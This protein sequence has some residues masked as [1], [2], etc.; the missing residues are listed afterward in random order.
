[1]ERKIKLPIGIENFE[2]IRRE[3]FYYIDKSGL[4]RELLDN[5]GEVNLFTRPRRFGKSLNMSMLKCFFE[6]GTDPALFDGL[7]ISHDDVL[8]STYMGQFP[9]VSISLKG[10]TG[11]SYDM[12]R[13]MLCA[14]IG[15]EAMRFQMLTESD[16][17]TDLEKRQYR[18]LVNMDDQGQFFFSD[19]VLMNSLLVLCK[20]LQKHYERKVIILIDEYDV[21]LDKAQQCGYYDVMISL[22]RNLFNQALK[23]NE[24]LYFSVLTGCL[25]ISKESIFTGLNNPK[26]LSITDVRFDEHFGF[27]DDEVKALLD[28]Y[29]LNEKYEVIREWYD[30][31]RFG[32]VDV[33]CPWDV[34]C[35][36]DEL[37]AQPN[38]QPG[39]YWTNTSDNAIVRRFLQ[40]AQKGTTRR[41]IEK[42]MAG[43]SIQ[44]EIHQELTYKD[45]DK[46]IDN[47]WSVL[48]TTGYLT[49]QGEPVG[50]VFWLKI[51]NQEIRNIFTKQIYS[52]FQ[53]TAEEDGV[54]LSAFCDA[55]KNGDAEKIER[56]FDAYLAKTISIRDTFVRRK[57]NF[58]HGILLGLLAYKENWS[59]S[60][61]NESGD[62][63]SDI[64]IEIDDDETGIIIEVKYSD[65]DNMLKCCEAAL[66]Q[67][68]RMNYEASLINNGM[69][70]VLKYGIACNKKHC[71]VLLSPRPCDTLPVSSPPSF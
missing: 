39:N 50:D 49:Q 11:T 68:D 36:C 10:V 56:Q 40:K 37:R 61:N 17:L 63:Y 33:Y 13:A 57:E 30:G 2:K 45:L 23:G 38:A 32:S 54:T 62:G 41:E 64:L 58:Y 20:L 8:C 60:S 59:V 12:A 51:P 67:I 35:Y 22:I 1:M 9:V 26:V 28:A 3:G 44:K 21:P 19:E 24:S 43:A 34:L 48:F 18:S 16:R 5:W 66:E 31:Y 27:T 47:L 29:D 7:E 25:R 15:N 65:S 14:V 46:T 52:W 69:K 70:K 71:R 55:F 4:I 6:I 42:L 53:E